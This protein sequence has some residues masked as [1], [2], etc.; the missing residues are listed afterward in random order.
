MAG[1]ARPR[2]AVVGAG[3][4]G[5]AA[6][7][8]LLH[9]MG[10]GVEVAVFEA[11]ARPGGKISTTQVGGIPVEAGADSFVVRKPWAVDLCNELG[12][13]E[14]L[15]VPGAAGA[16]V[17]TDGRLTSFPPRSAFGI[18]SRIGDLLGWRGL[19]LAARLR[20]ALDVYRPAR[21]G[22]GDEA[23]GRLLRRR[24]GAGAASVMVE[25]LLAG[26]HAGDPD[27]LS[28][29]ATFPEIAEWERRHGSLIKG[30]RAAVKASAEAGSGPMFATVWGGLDRMT[31]ALA[32][33][34][35]S[36]RLLLETPVLGLRQEAGHHLL[37]TTAGRFEAEAVV[38]AVPAFD[39]SRLL[40]GLVPEASAELSA[41]PYSSTAVVILAYPEGTAD[42]VPDG[43]GYV[44]PRGPAIVTACTWI[45][46]KWPTEDLGSRA[47]LRCFV[48]RAGSEEALD[49]TD[50]ELIDAVRAETEAVVPMGVR[51]EA[52]VIRWP[53]GMPQY[54]VGHL[55]RVEG[56]RRALDRTPGI[57]VAGSAYGGVG[58]PDCI[59]Q[60]EE[61]AG[62]VGAFLGATQGPWGATEGSETNGQEAIGW[63]M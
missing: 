38:L 49:L 20:A 53:R 4:T 28:I 19:P 36:G 23:L 43:T 32:S 62:R 9:S 44:T 52:A 10:E 16:Y 59:R 41:I 18:P 25:P 5:L 14:E 45:S 39:A 51:P 6:A 40:S 42:R 26:L 47:V 63:R 3:I 54:E 57:F 31:G 50:Q 13:G 2:V 34:L 8:R 61:A 58:I 37:E 27:R 22:Q 17:W 46:R 60:A 55:D 33:R 21:R 48:G 30:A 15:V 35:G 12:L 56:V 29:L 7:Y 1:P 11:G 24:L